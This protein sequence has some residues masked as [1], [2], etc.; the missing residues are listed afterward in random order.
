MLDEFWTILFFWFGISLG[1]LPW[2]VMAFHTW[3]GLPAYAGIVLIVAP[4]V[5]G[6]QQIGFWLIDKSFED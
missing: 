2:A 3:T 4:Y 1:V 6:S 5:I